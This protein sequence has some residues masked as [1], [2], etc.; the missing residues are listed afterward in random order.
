[1][2]IKKTFSLFAAICLLT[3]GFGSS[4]QAESVL[5]ASDDSVQL[6]DSLDVVDVDQIESKEVIEETE[7]TELPDAD[8]DSELTERLKG[9][10]LLEVEGKGEVYYVD[11]ENG[12]KEYLADG[13]SAHSLL[14]RR[15]LGITDANLEKIPVGEVSTDSSVCEEETLAKRLRGRILLQVESHGEAWYVYPEN[16]R[17]YFVGTFDQA[18]KIMKELSLG[19]KTESLAKIP[20]TEREQA[21]KRLRILTHVYSVRQDLPLDE[22]HAVVLESLKEAESCV[23]NALATAQEKASDEHLFEGLKVGIIRRCLEANNVPIATP[24]EK[25]EAKTRLREQHREREHQSEDSLDVEIK[26]KEEDGVIETEIEVEIEHE[27]TSSDDSSSDSTDDSSGQTEDN[28]GSDT[29]DDSG[30]DVEDASFGEKD[31]AGYLVEFTA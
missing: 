8:E 19:I 14:R 15:A 17:R 27:S 31:E 2:T 4:V 30:S 7:P 25:D 9:R 26:I 23:A 16:C 21:K 1:M 18:Y 22:A 3:F 12:E 11:P 20:D 5:D 6:V 29:E 13:E 10:L 24:E 28:S